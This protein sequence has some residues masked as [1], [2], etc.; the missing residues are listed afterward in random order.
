MNETLTYE[1]LAAKVGLGPD[2][3][4]RMVRFAIVSA[5]FLQEPEPG[6][7][8]HSA[9][10]AIFHRDPLKADAF[11]WDF[12]VA[13]RSAGGLYEALLLDPQA[14]EPGLCGL[15]VAHKIPDRKYENM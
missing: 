9:A 1:E 4:C 5:S 10:S 11:R 14:Q 2:I 12:N 15:S 8:G 7:V 6:R 13:F 3:L